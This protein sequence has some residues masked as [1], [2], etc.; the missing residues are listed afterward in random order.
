MEDQA[1]FVRFICTTGKRIFK[2]PSRI[3]AFRKRTFV[4]ANSTFVWALLFNVCLL[5][6]YSGWHHLALL[7][8]VG[9]PT[10]QWGVCWL[11]HGIQNS[12]EA[13]LACRPALSRDWLDGWQNRVNYDEFAQA[14]SCQCCSLALF[15]WTDFVLCLCWGRNANICNF[16]NFRWRF[17]FGF[18]FLVV[19][20]FTDIK[21]TSRWEKIHGVMAA[22]SSNIE[23]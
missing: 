21:K 2:E 9:S 18:L 12:M 22:A 23:I 5:S 19:K 4:N 13:I 1:A 15:D 14:P 11:R 16:T 20:G 3:F 7:F 6:A 10:M 8:A 17:I